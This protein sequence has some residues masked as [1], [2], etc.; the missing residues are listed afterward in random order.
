MELERSISA[1]PMKPTRVSFSQKPI[2][3]RPS[4]LPAGLTGVT[5]VT[6]SN[7]LYFKPLYISYILISIIFCKGFTYQWVYISTMMSICVK[8][9]SE[10]SI[11]SKKNIYIYTINTLYMQT[12]RKRKILNAKLNGNEFV[13]FFLN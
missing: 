4:V 6:P 3:P 12:Y 5:L 1:G 13:F 2:S 7:F 11:C 9:L 10:A 8:R